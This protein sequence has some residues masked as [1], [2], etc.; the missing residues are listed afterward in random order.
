[1]VLI[2]QNYHTVEN[3]KMRATDNRYAGEIT[4]FNL[5]V[6]MISHEARTGTIRHC[7][8]F[9]ED[10]IR[11]IYAT[12]FK[13]A[14]GT[15][16]KRH[17]GKSPTQIAPFVNSFHRQSEATLLAC[18]FFYCGVIDFDEADKSIK[19][20]ALDPVGLGERICEAYETYRALHPQPCLCLEK[21]WTLYNALVKEQEL[22]LAGCS[23]CGGPYVQDRFTID[24]K[25]CPFCE[26][27]QS[28]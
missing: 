22:I 23:K 26:L 20:K 19:S 25:N 14:S 7:T 6:R 27:K 11:K 4:R 12:Y 28:A 13:L 3:K 21:T 15:V 16:V 24:H 1:M 18:L 2:C 9:S 8:G 5:A 10:R 17:R